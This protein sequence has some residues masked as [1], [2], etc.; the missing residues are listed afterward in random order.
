[1]DPVRRAALRQRFNNAID[2]PMLILALAFVPLLI[3]PEVAEIS[4]ELQFELDVVDWII[5][6]AFAF[7][8]V[9]NIYLADAR[10][11]YVRQ[12]WFDVA[13]VLL[14][15][16]QP[17]RITRSVRVLRLLRAIR[18]VSV[19]ARIH[20]AIRDIFFV[21]GVQYVLA[22]AMLLLVI[23]AAAVTHF[24]R[25]A[26]GSINSFGTGPWWALT[27]VTTVGYGDTYPVTP[28]GRGI[29]VFVM[30]LGIGL[31]GT[32]T[33][34]V[35]AYFATSSE[36]PSETTLDDVLTEIRRLESRLDETLSERR[37]T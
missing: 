11:S 8:L 10:R 17:L 18:V 9:V 3:I 4:P 1:M 6:S 37:S 27:T 19:A 25:S 23:A 20:H 13:I 29:A 16:L 5:W 33:A 21:H 26:G 2:V 28:E 15:F 7:E 36:R 30:L 31:F 12:R 22:V 35:A 24:E 14:P 32:L 34:S